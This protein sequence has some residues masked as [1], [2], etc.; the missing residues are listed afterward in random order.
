MRVYQENIKRFKEFYASDFYHYLK[1]ENEG[2]ITSVVDS[3]CL[4][5]DACDIIL[6]EELSQKFNLPF[7]KYYLIEHFQGENIR[8]AADIVCGRRQMVQYY[9]GDEQQWIETYQEI[10]SNVALHFLWPKHKAPTINTYR[11]QKYLDRIDCLLYDL[12]YYFEGHQTP[13][14]SVYQSEMTA[15]WLEQ[16][17]NDFVL[18]IDK[19]QLLAFVDERYNVLD[20]SKGQKEVLS[21]VLNRKQVNDTILDYLGNLFLLNRQ[22]KF[23]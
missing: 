18:F 12:K 22:G 9:Q 13:M 20:I 2:F 14:S 3:L 7:K 4:D 10:R 6:Y 17:H 5:P 23:Y 19:M 1:E 16:F 21:E 11:Y 8:L 15:K